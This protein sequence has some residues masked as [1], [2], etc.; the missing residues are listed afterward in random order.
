MRGDSAYG[1]SNGNEDIIDV[2]EQRDLHYL[3]ADGIGAIVGTFLGSPFPPAVYIGHPGMAVAGGGAV[4]CALLLASIAVF[5]IDRRFDWAAVYAAM[6]ALFSF[7]GFIHSD[8]LCGPVKL[9]DG[10]TVEGILYPKEQI[11]PEH[12]DISAFAGW[13]GYMASKKNP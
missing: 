3:L 4:L 6:A 12:V 5:V 13:R 2:C 9:A 1:N 11:R 10:R 7:F 8:H